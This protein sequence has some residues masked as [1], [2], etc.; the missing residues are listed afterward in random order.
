VV[1]LLDMLRHAFVSRLRRELLGRRERAIRL[2]GQRYCEPTRV[3]RVLAVMTHIV[4]PGQG[5]DPETRARRRQCLMEALEAL[6]C[7]Q[8]HHELEVIINTYRDWHLLSDLPTHLRD[9]VGIV[10]HDVGDPMLVEFHAQ[11]LFLGRQ[12][13]FDWFLSL[14]DDICVYD[15]CFVEKIHEFTRQAL[16]DSLLLLPHRFEVYN[17]RKYYIDRDFKNIAWGKPNGRM[18]IDVIN[19]LTILAYASAFSDRVVRFAEFTNPHAA[20][21]CLSRRQLARWAATG[22]LWYRRI[23]WIGPLESAATGCLFERFRLYKPHPENKWY[24]EVRHWGTK[25]SDRLRR[26]EHLARQRA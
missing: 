10:R 11:D 22:R 7:S 15:S 17:S 20:T 4:P 16:D 3:H 21:Y 5:R 24:L 2:V 8:S 19:P 1:Y 18:A 13:H 23:S 12:E 25:Y 9:R 6:L 14:E 26:Y